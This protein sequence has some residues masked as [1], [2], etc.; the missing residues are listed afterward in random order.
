MIKKID[1]EHLKYKN[2]CLH[3]ELH[4]TIND[5]IQLEVRF[6]NLKEYCEDLSTKISH[7]CSFVEDLNK[8][9]DFEVALQFGVVTG[10][11][12]KTD[13]EFYMELIEDVKSRSRF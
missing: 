10:V 9:I 5:K 1:F 13:K 4:R 2:L 7:L 6:D 3:N 8:L 12:E 11:I